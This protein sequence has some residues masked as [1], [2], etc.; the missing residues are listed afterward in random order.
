MFHAT[1]ENPYSPP[2]S[3]RQRSD[4]RKS[5]IA[6]H[7]RPNPVRYVLNTI[8]LIPVAWSVFSLFVTWT[9]IKGGDNLKSAPVLTISQRCER[10]FV[11]G[12]VLVT[13]VMAMASILCLLPDS[14]A[15]E[16]LDC[17][18]KDCR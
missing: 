18:I 14:K 1:N 4:L 16:T 13:S 15:G 3:D 12:A 10:S 17:G 7:H 9:H 8:L 6:P 5:T 11:P 2:S